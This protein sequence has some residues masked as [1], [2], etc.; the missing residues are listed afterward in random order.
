MRV[1]GNAFR[2]A[3]EEIRK[4]TVRTKG[5]RGEPAR[6]TQEWL[7]NIALVRQE[8]GE[9]IP[10]SVRTIQ[11]LEKGMASIQTVDA[12][13]P[14]LGLNGRSLILDYGLDALTL[15]VPAVV[16]LRP[17]TCPHDYPTTFHHSAFLLS[18]DPLIIRFSAEDMDSVRL[19]KMTARVQ[20]G[21][22]S[23][24]FSWL[25]RVLLTP[26]GNGWLGIEEEVYPQEV[27]SMPFKASVM[28]HQT[29]HAPLSWENFVNLVE[30][31]D[32]KLVT[33]HL[34]LAFQY[35]TKD[36]VIALAVAQ[37]RHYFTF[38]R[39]KRGASW[40]FFSQPDALLLGNPPK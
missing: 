12:V 27:T 37:L 40:P 28:F 38:S 1:D 19:E 18:I 2:R 3:R 6:G 33:I 17:E 23:V 30:Q 32:S 11:Y 24:D 31:T 14:H 35:F 4:N 29:H 10:L 13:S 9:L 15:E 22:V 7:A 26:N 20:I 25:Y 5:K 39:N 21:E 34:T 16:D 8:N 36:L